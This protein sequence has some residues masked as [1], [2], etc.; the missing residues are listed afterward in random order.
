MSS[1]SEPP[2]PPASQFLPCPTE[3]GKLPEFFKDEAELC[4]IWNVPET[5]KRLLQGPA[6]KGF[7]RVRPAD[8]QKIIDAQESD[9]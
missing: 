2:S 4:S 1:R 6:E 3:D 7:G 9:L 8:M 5:R